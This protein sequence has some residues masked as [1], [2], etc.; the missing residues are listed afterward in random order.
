MSGKITVYLR[1]LKD[2]KFWYASW[3]STPDDSLIYKKVSKPTGV[4]ERLR[5]NDH[6]KQEARDVAFQLREAWIMEEK[7]ERKPKAPRETTYGEW[8]GSFYKENSW[9]LK[10]QIDDG[11]P[12]NS[13]WASDL[14]RMMRKWVLPKWENVPLSQFSPHEVE[15]WSRTLPLSSQTRRIITYSCFKVP[16]KEAV[17]GKIIVGNPLEFLKAPKVYHKKRDI[18][19]LPELGKLFPRDEEKL[20]EVWDDFKTA[21]AFALIAYTGCREGEARALTWGDVQGNFLVLSRAVKSTGLVGPLK[22][23]ELNPEPRVVVL[24]PWISALLE[25]LKR[26]DLFATPDSL[27][28]PSPSGKPYSS[29][30]FSIRLAKACEKAGINRDGRFLDVHSMRH[31]YNSY[32]RPVVNQEIAMALLGH[33]QSAVNENYNHPS[34]ESRIRQLEP[35][36]KTIEAAF[37]VNE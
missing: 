4:P 13:T 11:A 7:E 24:L 12:L 30:F 16:F 27:I 14:D 18:F 26:T 29:S 34:V 33:K 32:I 37:K 28:F 36:R 6:G 1:Q 2:G 9:Y 5:V 31:G 8:A 15:A 35:L 10:Q 3:R 22:K 23:R 21:V 25:Q 17:R 19:T 20:V